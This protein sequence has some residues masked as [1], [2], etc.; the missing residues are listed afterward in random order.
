[1]DNS[2]RGISIIYLFQEMRKLASQFNNEIDIGEADIPSSSPHCGTLACIGGWL[3]YLL[4][5]GK[6]S[7]FENGYESRVVHTDR[8]DIFDYEDGLNLFRKVLEIDELES[9]PNKL[10]PIDF[11]PAGPVDMIMGGAVFYDSDA[12][13]KKGSPNRLTD[14]DK[15][16]LDLVCDVWEEYGRRLACAE[17]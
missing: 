13:G 7:S 12:Y 6:V 2:S 14:S 15:L 16:S 9:L 1:M 11:I 17:E 10:W 5:D 8:E 4:W 3:F